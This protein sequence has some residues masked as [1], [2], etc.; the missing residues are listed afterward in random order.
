MK[1]VYDVVSQHIEVTFEHYL[2]DQRERIK[3]RQNINTP[4]NILQKQQNMIME[5]KY[6]NLCCMVLAGSWWSLHRGMPLHVEGQVVRPREGPV[7]QFAVEG[8]VPRVFSL[9]SGELV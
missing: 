9:V 2:H 5:H 8:S 7:T 6:N 1:Y 3:F 4:V